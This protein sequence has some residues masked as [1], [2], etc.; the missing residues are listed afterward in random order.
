MRYYFLKFTDDIKDGFGGYAK[1]PFIR[2]RPKY[3]YDLGLLEHEKVHVRQWY[4][5][6]AIG[7]VVA[8]LVLAAG[9]VQGLPDLVMIAAGIAAGS[10]GYH[11]LLYV[12]LR[13]YRLA[14]EVSAYRTQ[15]RQ[16][17]LNADMEFAVRAL[18]DKYKLGLTD[19]QARR[20]LS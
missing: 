3:R 14:C 12:T 16:Y 19:D 9:L 15:L 18:V 13:K 4:S 17:G 1:G 11:G 10:P 20:L 6:L 7:L 8:G 5:K 2:M